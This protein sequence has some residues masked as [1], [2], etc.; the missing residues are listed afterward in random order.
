MPP[1]PASSIAK[2]NLHRDGRDALAAEAERLAAAAR[3]FPERLSQKTD[4]RRTLP[5]D[6]AICAGL[7]EF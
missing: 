6:L 4:W 2:N 1:D 5:T 3:R 7:T